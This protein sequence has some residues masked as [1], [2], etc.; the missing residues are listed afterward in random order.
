MKNASDTLCV[1]TSFEIY[2][3]YRYG[4]KKCAKLKLTYNLSINNSSVSVGPILVHIPRL[5]AFIEMLHKYGQM[6]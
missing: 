4:L 3:L 6:F 5:C 1:N 2:I